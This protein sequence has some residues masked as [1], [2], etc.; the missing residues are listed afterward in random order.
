[1]LQCEKYETVLS[2][3]E[4]DEEILSF[5]DDKVIELAYLTD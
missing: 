2:W 4:K 1:M 3:V 5:V